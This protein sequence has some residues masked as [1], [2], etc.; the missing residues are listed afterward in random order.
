MTRSAKTGHDYTFF[1]NSCL[2]NIYNLLSQVYP[3]AKFQIHM[4]ITLGVTTLQSS[5]N[6]KSIC[7]ASIGKIKYRC[8][9][10]LTNRLRYGAIIF[11]MV[12]TMNRGISYW[13]SFSFIRP[14]SLHTKTKFVK[15]IDRVRS[16]QHDVNK[17]S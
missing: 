4:P 7:T 9:Q 5:N 8:L 1:S 14:S 2:L 12:F 3:L 15:K 10:K 16:L 17:R 13:V 11:T 6:R